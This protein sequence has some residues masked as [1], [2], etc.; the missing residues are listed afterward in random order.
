D[1]VVRNVRQILFETISSF[2]GNLEDEKDLMELIE[3]QFAA[4]QKTFNLLVE[5]DAEARSK[6]ASKLLNLYRIGR[7]GHYTL[8]YSK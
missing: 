3:A 5:S 8:D 4:L 6:V 1:F 2:H 7:L